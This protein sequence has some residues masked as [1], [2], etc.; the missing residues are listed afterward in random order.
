VVVEIRV[1]QS[2]AELLLSGAKARK[3]TDTTAWNVDRAMGEKRLYIDRG[4]RD[5]TPQANAKD[6]GPASPS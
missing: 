4:N 2:K 1:F 5:E 6:A 3:L